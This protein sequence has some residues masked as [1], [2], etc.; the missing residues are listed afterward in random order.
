MPLPSRPSLFGFGPEVKLAFALD[1]KRRFSL[2]FAANAMLYSLPWA[3]WQAGDCSPSCVYTLVRQDRDNSFVFS[4]GFYPSYA[5]G[6][7]GRLGN[8]FLMLGA[9]TDFK[10]DGFTDTQASGSTIQTSGLVG[11]IG[12]GGSLHVGGAKL[13]LL[14][15]TPFT[16]AADGARQMP[17]AMLTLGWDSRPAAAA[18]VPV[19]AAPVL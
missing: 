5:F 3:L 16:R 11:L 8:V 19:A 4:G 15:F 17:G 13:G 2:G 10:N 1:P 18:A 12:G 7:G 14:L 9:H 6:D